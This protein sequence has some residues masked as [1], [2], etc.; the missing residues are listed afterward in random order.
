MLPLFRATFIDIALVGFVN[1]TRQLLSNLSGNNGSLAATL[2]GLMSSIGIGCI[3]VLFLKKQSF[4]CKASYLLLC[5]LSLL[6]AVHLVNR[7][8][9]VILVVSILV[10]FIASTKMNISKLIPTFFAVLV[11]AVF[12]FNSGIIS[13]E[14]VEAYSARENDSS[15]DASSAG[16]RTELWLAGLE[17]LFVHPLGWIAEQ[18]HHNLWLD[19]A[20][21]GGWFAF[22]PFCYVTL[23]FIKSWIN[24]I[25][26]NTSSVGVIIVTVSFAS[27]LNASVEPTIEGSMLFF[28]LLMMF[29][30]MTK[31]IS[32]ETYK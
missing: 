22:V 12:L 26:F 13:P 10:S 3:S 23:Q 25:R 4:F 18:Y 8:G 31:R 9:L 28:C 2:Y 5:V 7:T 21:V 20:K 24:V 29:W 30:G 16:G 14:I 19:L 27:L 32:L 1:E 15:Y 17:R 6:S 11:L